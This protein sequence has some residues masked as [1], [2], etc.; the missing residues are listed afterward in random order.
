V[1]LFRLVTLWLLLPAGLV[2]LGLLRRRGH[3]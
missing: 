2:S 3:L 1:A